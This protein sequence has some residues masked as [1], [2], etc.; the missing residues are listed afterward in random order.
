[1]DGTQFFIKYLSYIAAF[2]STSCFVPQALKAISSDNTKSVSLFGY[3]LLFVGVAL[4]SLYGFITS[5]PA[6]FIANII[7]VI[8]VLIILCKKIYNIYKKID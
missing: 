1:M 4:W 2:F 3:A 6:I 7:V 8:L 5:Q